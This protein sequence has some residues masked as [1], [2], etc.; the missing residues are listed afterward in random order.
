MKLIAKKPCSFGGKKFYIG[1]EIPSEYVLNPNMQEKLGVIA[2]IGDDNPTPTPAAPEAKP[3]QAESLE[4][5]IHAKEGDIP[6][7]LSKEGLQ[8]VVDALTNNVQEAEE[9]VAQMT[10]GDAL[11]LLDIADTRKSIK[12]AAKERAQALAAEPENPEESVGD[13]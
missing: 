5:F 6:L 4:V 3:V 2:I 11:I 10:D 12:N 7:H 1:E 9:I 13:Q 8:A